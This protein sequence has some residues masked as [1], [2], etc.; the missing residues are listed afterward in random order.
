MAESTGQQDL[1]TYLRILWRWKFL[2]LAFL[3]LIPVGTYFYERG[4]PKTY[5]SS[6]LIAIQGTS[7]DGTPITPENVAAVAQLVTTTPVAKKAAA[8]MQHPPA[9]PD[10]LLNEV[11]ASSDAT[12]D[13]VTIT[14]EDRS[15]S[16]A[17]AIAN[18]FAKAL[19][20]AQNAQSL[21][22]VNQQIAALKRQLRSISPKDQ[23]SRSDV[24]SELTQLRSQKSTAGSGAQV[25]QPALVPTSPSGPK[26]RRA[27]ELALVIALLLAVGAVVIAENSDRRL[28]T[29]EDLEALTKLPLLGSV[30]SSAFKPA[31][32]QVAIDVEA[33]QMLRASLTYFNVDQP[34]TSVAIISPLP[35]DGKTTV[36]VGLAVAAARAG[37]TAI[38]IDADLRNPQACTRLSI[39]PT[40]GLG[41][42]LAGKAEL[43]DVL[44]EY[45]FEMPG[46]GRLLVLPS[47]LGAPPPNPSALL[48]SQA[49]RDLLRRLEQRADLVVVDTPAALSVSDA[50]PLVQAASGVAIIVRM[51][52]SSRAAVR[53][54][55]K[56]IDST[57]GRV[58]GIVAT[59]FAA[60][61]GAYNY[62]YDAQGEKGPRRRRFLR[63]RKRERITARTVTE[64]QSD[65]SS[66][67]NG[68]VT[69]EFEPV[70]GPPGD[71]RREDA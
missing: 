47:H 42:V 4:K 14:V 61:A 52:R 40:P 9:N 2:F 59:G 45:P 35:A 12:T 1:R 7:V 69:T 49:M 29:P 50:L 65:E 67:Q 5:E 71:S 21:Q 54:L 62:G 56:V 26:T 8:F 60:P 23:V 11:S 58:I 43:D 10:S 27:V 20:T 66:D 33:F 6:T 22:S 48:S 68:G 44:L 24:V 38:L 34:L 19:G 25:V 30:P 46:G 18:A 63:R 37:R 17:A 64:L 53:R 57:H 36:A 41:A 3:V 28:R 13:Y 16:R 32:D 31:N 15:P 70:T 39:E 51:N 55:Q